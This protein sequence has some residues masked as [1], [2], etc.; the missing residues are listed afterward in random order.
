[1]DEKTSKKR[2]FPLY[3]P[4]EQDAEINEFVDNG[5]AKSQNDFINKAIEFYIGYLRNNKNLDYI[6][7]ILSSVMK[8]QMQDIERN[9]SEM[10]FKLAVEV[11]KQNHIAVSR[12]ELDED[13]LYPQCQV[14]QHLKFTRYPKRDAIRAY[15]PLPNE[16]FSLGL[17]T[18][19]IA[20]YAYLMYCE[21]R[22]TF[23]CHPSYKTI[24]NA[25]GMSK[26]TVKKYVDSLI[27]KQLI[28]A[29][30]T[31]VITQKGEK[32]NGNLRYT[33][34]PIAEALEQYYEQQLIRL[35]EENRCQ[36]ALKK[37]AE[38]DRKHKKSAV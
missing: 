2:R 26:N 8:S 27:E 18:G 11:A 3:I 29:E 22:K 15:F 32:R 25:V 21:D 20:V 23:Q 35:H 33:I 16:I 5:Y 38:F 9:L 30:P 1:M 37:L 4:A 24:G 36:S 10:L 13:T 7:P 6:A 31:S 17:S 14:R 28:T 34:R 12:G 19:E